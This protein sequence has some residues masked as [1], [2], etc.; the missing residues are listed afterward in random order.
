MMKTLI[1]VIL[2]AVLLFAFSG[3]AATSQAQERQVI[4]KVE[5]GETLYSI[6]RQYDVT[7]EN[8]KKWNNISDNQI[9]VGQELVIKSVGPSVED[10]PVIHTVQPKETLFSISKQYHVSIAALKSWNEL[11]DTNLDVGQKLT[12]YPGS[13]EKKDANTSI[14]VDSNTSSNTYYIVKSGDTLYQIA[15]EHNMT[16]E[17]LKELNDLS[18]NVIRVGQRLTVREVKSAPSVTENAEESSPQGE[19]ILHRISK[20]QSLQDLLSRFNMDESEFR[21]LNPDLETSSFMPGQKVTVLA[22]PN[23]NFEN[24]YRI[25]ANMKDLGTVGVTVYDSSAVGTTTTSGELYN[26]RQLTAAHSNI[27]IGDVI[28][29]KKPGGDR[30][31]FVRINDRTSGNGLKLSRAAYR[32]LQFKSEDSA[33]VQIF[34]NQ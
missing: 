3:L 8:L 25:D 12:I 33:A 6:A 16:L 34:Q 11:K 1:R 4:H 18:S 27:A 2:G 29:I 22:P 17:E 7:V 32:A 20:S 24:P 13:N 14:V 30:G 15:R 28:F 5:V 10:E 9:S 19:F 26:P 21:A 23:R 31:L